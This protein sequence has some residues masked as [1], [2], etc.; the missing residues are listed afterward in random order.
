MTLAHIQVSLFDKHCINEI[1]ST[2]SWINSLLQFSSNGDKFAHVQ[3]SLF[4][5]LCINESELTQE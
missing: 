5:K 1:S 3:V 4:D 2:Y